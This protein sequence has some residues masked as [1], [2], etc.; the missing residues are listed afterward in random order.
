MTAGRAAVTIREERPDDAA[1]VRSVIDAAFAPSEDEGRIVHALRTSDAWIP[2]LA[3]VAV[4][5]DGSVVGQCVT[6][7]GELTGDDGRRR[8]ILGL[9]P[10]SVAPARQGEGIGSAL[11]DAS[12]AQATDL[13]WPIIVLLGH[14]TYYPRFGF[15]SARDLGIAPQ[16]DWADEH[17]M[18]RR[19]PGWTPALRGTMRYPPAF[20]ID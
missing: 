3:L 20:G 18:A 2:E 12:I 4:D 19:L 16:A 9:G 15:E 11:I 13:G 10:V 14:A 7:I 17:W 1:V 5:A 8:G 6:S